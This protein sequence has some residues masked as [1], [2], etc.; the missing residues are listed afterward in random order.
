MSSLTLEVQLIAPAGIIGPL[1]VTQILSLV[2]VVKR[3]PKLLFLSLKQQVIREKIPMGRG[4][5]FLLCL[6]LYWI[7][8]A[9]KKL[10][11]Y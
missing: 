5:P 1:K 6:I 9:R 8:P 7:C 11:N 10:A 4:T 3:T 2:S